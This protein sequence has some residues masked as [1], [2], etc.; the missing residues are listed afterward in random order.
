MTATRRRCTEL[1]CNRK[2]EQGTNTGLCEDH[3][4]EAMMEND[5]QDGNHDYDEECPICRGSWIS[6]PPSTPAAPR[7]EPT[8]T[9]R[10]H[11]NC[12]HPRTPAGRAACRKGG[13]P[14]A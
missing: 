7:T 2:A 6:E 3:N 12:S 14:Q 9:N 1:N 13:G 5:H 8:R 4:W 11:A 10:S